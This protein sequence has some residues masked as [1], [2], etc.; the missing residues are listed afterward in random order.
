MFWPGNSIGKYKILEV[1]GEGGFGK[2]F[3]AIDTWM[4]QE[5]AI[6]VPHNQSLAE[7]KLLKEPKILAALS[8]PHI[9]RIYTVERIHDIYFLVI[10]YVDGCSM[11][12]IHKTKPTLSRA[13][14]WFVQIA[15][16]MAYA[17]RN[18][19]LHRDI[20]MANILID[21]QDR[22]K[23]T[24][25]GAGR[26]WET[27]MTHAP[28]KIGTPEFMSPEAMMGKTVKQSDLFSF[29]VLMYVFLTR[30]RP[31]PGETILEIF[32]RMK[33]TTPIAPH[34]LKP[35]IPPALSQLVL[36]GLAFTPS[37]RPE[38]FEVVHRKLLAIQTSLQAK[39]NVTVTAPQVPASAV[40][41]NETQA[42][43]VAP[44]KTQASQRRDRTLC[45]NCGRPLA[46]GATQCAHP[47]CLVIQ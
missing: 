44:S 36:Q 12:Q 5:V 39:T 15:D 20:R 33:Q 22:A 13:L 4:N 25:F 46:P 42:W 38:S 30:Q 37:K 21:R 1:V 47:K 3:R 19:V 40:T 18:Q 43:P 29:S 45:W 7:D 31:F 32:N 6:K 35:G 11:R 28:T 26:I 2:V 8:H 16:A 14:N 27:N 23:I 10:E 41:T 24:D 17:H 9:V 34:I